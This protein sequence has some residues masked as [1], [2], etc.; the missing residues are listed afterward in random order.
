MATP[1][2]QTAFTSGELSP[3]L[4]GRVDLAKYAVGASTYRNMFVNYRGGATSRPG[5]RFVG[6]SAQPG[7]GLPP[8]LIRFQFNNQQGYALEFGNKY[9]RVISNGG[10]VTDLATGITGI[11][12]ANPVIVEISGTPPFSNG[13]TVFLSG[14]TGPAQLADESFIVSQAQPG[15]FA[16]I[17]LDGNPINGTSF[18][19]FT[20]GGT[21]ARVLTVT[22]PYSSGDLPNLKFTQ[23]ADVM[24]FTHPNYPPYDLMRLSASVWHFTQTTFG[25]SISAPATATATAS[26][27]TNSTATQFAYV[28]TA[29]DAVTGGE[30][31]ASPVALVTNS[32]DI[33]A[34]AGSVTITWDDTPGAGTYN[35]YKAPPSYNATQPAGNLFGFLG[36]SY[37]NQ[38]VDSNITQDMTQVPPLHKNPFAQ[39]QVIGVSMTAPG[40]G[41]DATTT[42]GIS[43]L[44]GGGAVLQPVVVSG[45]VVA[46]IVQNPGFGYTSADTLLFGGAGSGQAGTLTVGPQTG[47]YP[48]CVA[49]FQQRRVYANTINQ[50]DTYF[51][52]QPGAFTNFDARVP[53]IGS[54]AITGTPWS[55]QVNGIQFLVQ[56]P[57]GLIVLT[58][59]GAWQIEGAGGSSFNPVGITPA[60]QSAQPQAY[61]GCSATVPPLTINYNI[62]YVQSKGS[63]VR[64]LSY[65]FYANIYTGT[66][67]TVL[68]SHL[69]NNRLI[70]EWAWSEEPNKLIW[71]VRDDGVLLSCTYL[72][73]QEITGW[74]RHDTNGLFVSVCTVTEPPVDAPYFAVKRYIG[75]QWNYYI[76]RM[77]NRLWTQAEG[78]WCVDCGLQYPM[79]TPAANLTAS[80]ASGAAV[81][82]TADAAVFSGGNVGSV[83]RMGGG[84]ATITAVPDNQHVVAKITQNIAAVIPDGNGIPAPAAS[85]S[86][87]M[88][89][90]ISVI[91]G[92][93]HLNGQTVTGLADGEVIPPQIVVNDSITL[94]QPATAIIVGLGFTAQL[95]TLYLDMG[96]GAAT[97]QGR[98]KNIY[99]VVVRTNASRGLAVGTNQVDASVSPTGVA[100]AWSVIEIKDRSNAIS[101]DLPTPLYTGDSFIN[102]PGDWARPGQVA[103]QQSYPLPA[104]VSA[105]ISFVEIGDV[106]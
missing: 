80:A 56:M 52:S 5:T 84:I 77:D 105:L 75:G 7:S 10:Y 66:D 25:S 39:G 106:A 70:L 1:K 62:I 36:S 102:V 47:T 44:T 100:P 49:Y 18:S 6:R 16:L 19:A 37:G 85:G 63:I 83:L 32:V 86:W 29:V 104:E 3:E 23:S 99:S 55:Q 13:D 73:E 53:T 45:G 97:V 90:P 48:S 11:I 67:I 103:I 8:R 26:V 88:T 95:Q 94:E 15:S 22:T 17:D 20:G 89:V 59:L 2:I 82:F 78:A 96:A 51:M 92:L 12:M 72:K 38:F 68:S 9:V 91:S 14:F 101:G 21:A 35:V 34:T 27:T 61:N 79:P 4:F 60:N 43:S 28:A 33:A 40:S 98:R 41:A 65:N 69:F 87:S 50:P 54:D 58:G 74:T 57:S 76:E 93:G 46:A 30:S 24:S 31:V 71:A 64:D 81:T 42:I